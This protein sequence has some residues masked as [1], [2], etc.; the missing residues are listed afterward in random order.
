[1]VYIN[2]RQTVTDYSKWRTMFDADNTRRKAAGATGVSQVFRD[3][4]DPNIVTVIVEWDNAEKASKFL[5][6]PAL[7]EVMQKAGVVGMPSLIAVFSR[8]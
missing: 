4:E 2:V 5:Q 6:D 8:T 3:V 7:G 1:M